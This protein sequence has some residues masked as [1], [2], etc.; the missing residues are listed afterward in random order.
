MEGGLRLAWVLGAGGMLGAALRRALTRE[1]TP[2]FVPPS[3]FAWS[4]EDRVRQQFEVAT[5]AFAAS[6]P[7]GWHW[8]VY[9][10]AG[11][12]S[13]ASDRDTL[14]RESRLLDCLLDCLRRQPLR[15]SAGTL[16]LASSAGALYAG[17]TDEVIHETTQPAPTTEYARAK[18]AQERRLAE[19]VAASGGSRAVIARFSTL[20]GRQPRAEKKQGLIAAMA[21]SIVLR[22]PIQIY[23]PLDTIRDYLAVDDAAEAWVALMRSSGFRE[24]TRII[25]SGQ[26]TTVSEIV[27]T[28]TRIAHRAPRIVTSRSD[29]SAVYRRRIQFRTGIGALFDVWPRTSLA[30]GISRLLAAEHLAHARGGA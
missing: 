25:A 8:E 29:L 5:R 16:A 27:A 7:A 2:V 14:A 18:Q 26:V 15:P 10:A 1:G 19:F 21:R 6:I 12:G 11:L 24:T 9:W 17:N 3:P 20:Y 22:R 23:V 4:E 30:I 13:F 28:F